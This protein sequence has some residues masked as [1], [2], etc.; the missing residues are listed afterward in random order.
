MWVDIVIDGGIVDQLEC[1]LHCRRGRK[2]KHNQ[3]IH[4]QYSEDIEE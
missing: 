4:N 2:P 3:N 1:I